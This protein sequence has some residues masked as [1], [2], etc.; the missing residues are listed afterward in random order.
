[1]AKPYKTKKPIRKPTR[2]PRSAVE[3]VLA[4]LNARPAD[5]RH[6]LFIENDEAVL[7]LRRH[8]AA[9]AAGVRFWAAGIVYGDR[10][11][12]LRHANG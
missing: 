9:S 11:Y 12:S 3:S 1:M 10:C 8:R 5:L 6:P 4:R 7:L 2:K